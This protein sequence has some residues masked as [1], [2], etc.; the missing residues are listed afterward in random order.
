MSIEWSISEY[1]MCRNQEIFLDSLH[2]PH[3]VAIRWKEAAQLFDHVVM[4]NIS[5][6][7]VTSWNF[8][9][10]NF[11]FVFIF[12]CVC[13]LV[14]GSGLLENIINLLVSFYTR[15]VYFINNGPQNSL[16]SWAWWS[17]KE[18]S[19]KNVFQERWF[20]VCLWVSVSV[21]TLCICVLLCVCLCIRVIVYG[22]VPLSVCVC[23]FVWLFVGVFV[24][25]YVCVCV[26]IPIHLFNIWL[27]IIQLQS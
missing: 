18:D 16:K 8:W 22:C 7:K 26:C 10:I 14:V 24:C 4:G 12:W 21:C 5:H 11:S 15:D 2:V 27:L 17:S 23:L 1:R 19:Q 20:F 6:R 13:I 25:V 3:Q 9:S